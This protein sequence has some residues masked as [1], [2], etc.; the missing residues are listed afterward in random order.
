MAASADRPSGAAGRQVSPYCLAAESPLAV[1]EAHARCGGAGPLYL[2]GTPPG[3][4]P[5]LPAVACRCP[6]HTPERR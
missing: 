5:V 2:P 4:A 1:S 3:G 6:C